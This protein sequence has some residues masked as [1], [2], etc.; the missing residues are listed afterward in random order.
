MKKIISY[1]PVLFSFF[2]LRAQT[3]AHWEY[4]AVRTADRTYEIHLTVTLDAGWHAYSQV[5]PAS[6]VAVPTKIVFTKN[7]LVMLEGKIKEEGKLEKWEDVSTGIS[8]DQYA[9][10]VDFVQVVKLKADAKTGLG[11]SVTFQVCTSSMCLP[12]KTMPFSIAI[13]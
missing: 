4:R 7:P 11:G 12:P 10:K 13:N 2:V 9:D 6:A 3:P 5:Q 8:A 1:I